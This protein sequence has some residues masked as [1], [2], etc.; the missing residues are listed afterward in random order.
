MKMGRLLV[1]QWDSMKD[2]WILDLNLHFIWY[3]I[4]VD[5]TLF[6]CAIVLIIRV[7]IAHVKNNGSWTTSNSNV[8]WHNSYDRATC[9]KLR[10]S[11][12]LVEKFDEDGCELFGGKGQL[13]TTK[14]V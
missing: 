1:V 4:E 5:F 6:S 2:Q 8:W 3:C 10:N 14:E 11:L 9:A 13:N 12:L 7:I